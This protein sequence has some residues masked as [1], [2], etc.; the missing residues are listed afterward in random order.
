MSILDVDALLLELDPA[1]PCGPDLEYDPTFVALELEALG[2]PEVQYGST[3]TAA[4]GPD[5]KAVRRMARDLF[6]RSR[7]LR[8][9][10]H[11]LRAELALSG[12]AG[13]A[14]GLHLLERLLEERWDSVHPALDPDD[15]LDPTLRINSLAILADNGG[16]LRAVKDAT[17]LVLPVLGP[18]T[19]RA[20]DLA[21]VDA[22]AGTETGA[23]TLVSIENALKDVDPQQLATTVEALARALASV[24]NIEVLLVRQV[25]SSQA[26]NLDNLTRPLRKAQEFLARHVAI[27]SAAADA[28]GADPAALHAGDTAQGAAVAARAIS[29]DIGNRDDVNRMLD[30]LLDYYR[31]HE[32]SS[33]IPIL[34]ARA[35]RLV[36][37]DFF[38]IMKDLAP[39]SLAQLSVIRGPEL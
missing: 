37:M 36:P 30:K 33:P 14:A 35:K 11:L 2:K 39:D 31:L 29:G 34:L 22:Q 15:D 24:V 16:L 20:L 3:I 25:G 12:L 8:L 38:E 9:A 19:M 6:D 26:L 32:P 1:A 7:D 17:L 18:L 23:M 4:V 21:I 10:V 28:G 5:W 13:L 27:E